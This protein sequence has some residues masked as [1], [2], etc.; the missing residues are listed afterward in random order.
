MSSARELENAR[1]RLQD[2]LLKA[3]SQLLDE[4]KKREQAE[5]MARFLQKRV[6]LLIKVGLWAEIP[7]VGLVPAFSLVVRES[8]GVSSLSQ[9]TVDPWE[10]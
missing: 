6:Q 9:G 1:K 5:T 2:E 10:A 3:Q 8:D 4:K 7:E